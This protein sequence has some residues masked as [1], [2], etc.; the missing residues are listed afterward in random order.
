MSND[1]QRTIDDFREAV[2]NAKDTAAMNAIGGFFYCGRGTAQNKSESFKWYS[3]SASY[4]DIDAIKRVAWCYELGEGV[5]QS[6]SEAVK[7][8]IKAAEAG[9]IEAVNALCEIYQAGYTD[10]DLSQWQDK[11]LKVNELRAVIGDGV[12]MRKV[13]NVHYFNG[14]IQTAQEWYL[15]AA[16]YGDIKAMNLLVKLYNEAGDVTKA[17]YWRMKLGRYLFSKSY[18]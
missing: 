9:D 12:A 1:T 7:Y 10:E 5:E 3:L 18:Y 2:K 16:Q 8:Y 17:E 14:D 6:L 15:K 13:G 11:A 4:G